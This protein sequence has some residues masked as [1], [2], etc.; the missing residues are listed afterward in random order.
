MRFPIKTCLI[1]WLILV[2]AVALFRWVQRVPGWR[3]NQYFLEQLFHHLQH[4]AI[5]KILPIF[6][7]HLHFLNCI[8]FFLPLHETEDLFFH[9]TILCGYG[10]A[11]PGRARG[12]PPISNITCRLRHTFAKIMEISHES[13]KWF[14]QCSYKEIILF[15]WGGKRRMKTVFH[16]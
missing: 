11:N 16:L 1:P 10:L 13:K 14:G 8:Q 15:H 6:G 5:G 2:S 9:G 7:L 3:V 12:S 4:P